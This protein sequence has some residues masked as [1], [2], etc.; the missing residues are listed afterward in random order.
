MP[1]G[2][3]GPPPRTGSKESSAQY[4]AKSYGPVVESIQGGT[5]SFITQVYGELLRERT[6][7]FRQ[8]L[9]LAIASCCM[10]GIVV[11]TLVLTD[12]TREK[13]AITAGMVAAAFLILAGVVTPWSRIGRANLVNVTDSGQVSARRLL[14]DRMYFLWVDQ[15]LHRSLQHVVSVEVGLDEQLDAVADPWAVTRLE[16]LTEPS[17]LPLGTRLSSICGHRG[18]R[19]MLLLGAPG[20]G[21]TTHLLQL[22]EDLINVATDDASAPLPVV[23]RLSEWSDAHQSLAKWVISELG[24]RYGIPS[25]QALRWLDELDVILLLDG[26]DE[27]VSRRRERCLQAIV[28]FCQDPALSGVGLVVTCRTADFESLRSRL[29]VDYAV[30]VR[31]LETERVLEVLDKLGSPMSALRSAMLGSA[32]LTEL[33]TTPLMLGIAILATHGLPLTT[34]MPAHMVYPLYVRR[35]LTRSRTLRESGPDGG[36]T[37]PFS[38]EATRRHLIWLARLMNRNGQVVFYPDWITPAWLP[39]RE[40]DWQVPRRRGPIAALASHVGWDHAST[41]FVGAIFAGAL[42]AAAGA[43][44]GAQVDGWKGALLVSGCAGIV[45]AALAFTAFGLLLQNRRVGRFFAPWLGS[46]SETPYSAT[47][48]IWS[49]R[50]FSKGLIRGC[51]CALVVASIGIPLTSAAQGIGVASVV[52]VGGGL[53]GGNV[54]DNDEPPASPGRALSV[55]LR[56]LAFLITVLCAVVLAGV[57]VCA[58]LNGPWA[59]A[60]AALPLTAALMLMSGPGRAW[61]RNRAASVGLTSSGLLPGQ[62]TGFLLHADERI[63][64]RRAGGGFQFLHRT[65]QDFLA[66]ENPDHFTAVD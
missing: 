63:L 1:E 57:I 33:L 23:L 5:V 45:C 54:P 29:P 52:I 2:D 3:A 4:V 58:T 36:N 60:V 41:A 6:F 44:L 61:L 7:S 24:V 19:R 37:L 48:W 10:A 55:S 65:L 8:R 34:P 62:L 64:M 40:A 21:K 31:P 59:A 15:A 20:S 49:W 9:F 22:A 35:M 25:G 17:P 53:S 47:K 42:S 39:D 46:E 56:R 38:P 13:N 43:P 18:I 12:V 30:R 66:A 11:S 26:L 28:Q 32:Q 27:V 14:L 51:G 50:G 16:S